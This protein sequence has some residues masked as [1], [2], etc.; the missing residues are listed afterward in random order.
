MSES[1]TRHESIDREVQF[2]P[3]ALLDAGM[4]IVS[5]DVYNDVLFTKRDGVMYVHIIGD[6]DT[7]GRAT[8]IDEAATRRN[9]RKANGEVEIYAENPY[10]V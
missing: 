4:T 2:D 8:H 9:I 1:A 5:E 7:L 10:D 6:D 3:I